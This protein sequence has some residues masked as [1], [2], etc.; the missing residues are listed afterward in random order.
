[1]TLDS[2][3]FTGTVEHPVQTGTSTLLTLIGNTLNLLPL[4]LLC[5]P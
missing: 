1:V 2:N 4:D 5:V 3:T